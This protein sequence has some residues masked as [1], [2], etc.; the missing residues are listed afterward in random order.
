MNH[1]D[2][3]DNKHN[4]KHRGEH[5]NSEHASEYDAF[6]ANTSSDDT[7]PNR[8]VGIGSSAGGLGALRRFF[9]NM[10][11]DTGMAFVVI[12]HLSPE[13]DSELPQLLQENTT[14]SLASV[15]ED[16]TTLR[17]NH[18]YVISPNH[19][20][21][22]EGGVLR[23]LERDPV[24]GSR[25]VIDVFFRALAKDVAERA[26]G[27]VL[28]GMGSDGSQ[29]I[30]DIKEQGGI[31]I[32]QTPED[33]EFGDMPRNAAHLCAVDVVAPVADIPLALINLTRR[34]R[35]LPFLQDPEDLTQDDS[36]VLDNLLKVLRDK[37][38]HDF[39]S[40]KR[41]TVLRRLGRR[42]NVHNLDDLRDYLQL[43][44]G[45]RHEQDALFRELLISV[46]RFFR[47]PDTFEYVAQT[48][49]PELFERNTTDQPVRVWVTGCATG[50]EAYTL[51][52]LL[53]EHNRSL[54]A[55]R[56][57]QVFA[58]D[59]DQ[60]ALDIA[61]AG[62][63]PQAIEVDVSRERLAYFFEARAN[64]GT[65]RVK[66]WLREM[67]IFSPHNVVSDPP[68]ARLDMIS[69]RNMLIYFQSDLRAQVFAT[70]HYALE[71][72]G[73][74]LL[75]N[76]EVAPQKTFTARNRSHHIFAR[77]EGVFAL[78][79]RTLPSPEAQ[80]QQRPRQ[81]SQQEGSLLGVQRLILDHYLPPSV[82]VNDDYEVVYTVGKVGRYLELPAG[83]P[84]Y[85]VLEMAR[86]G[87]RLGLRTALMRVFQQHQDATNIILPLDTPTAND[88]AS[89]SPAKANNCYP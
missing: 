31:T 37:I 47:D 80:P 48:I 43:L 5:A 76:A 19:R 17:A 49:I 69:C 39:T 44:R 57:V 28:S 30:R 29:G 33:A 4:D 35:H 87:L 20:L 7:R 38:G 61:R 67:V 18:V 78:P 88:L 36:F 72:Q 89:A 54:S 56:K 59:I 25:S 2:K 65:Y 26:V 27:I 50:E 66:N 77:N 52:M 12:Q 24:S 63:Y 21:G 16:R 53:H 68:F 11:E 58:S 9:E 60:T 8:V 3:N 82:L 42:M 34:E 41:S 14:M 62:V 83:K 79:R 23:L 84:S 75:G 74:L 71:P 51:A 55:P 45:S 70:F 40:Y 46:T 13:Y 73:I 86:E 6:S 85:N 15:N 22:I 81:T 1:N 64:S 10:P 32:V